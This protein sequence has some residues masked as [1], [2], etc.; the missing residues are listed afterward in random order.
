MPTPFDILRDPVTLMLLAMFAGLMLWE[1][2]FP[3]RPLPRV[4][5][6]LPR[7]LASAIGYVMLSS[8]LPLPWADALAPLQV[9]DLSAWPTAAAAVV[10]V[11]VYESGAYAYHRAMHRFARE[12]GYWHGAS[13]RVADM[14]L[15]RDVS[16]SPRR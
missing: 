4:R 1:R 14:L 16:S 15:L 11:L 6:W 5:G 10:G 9:F 13:A 12:T 8:Y 3:G 7:G 2:L